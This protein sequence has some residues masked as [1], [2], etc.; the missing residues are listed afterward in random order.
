M[1]NYIFLMIILSSRLYLSGML[2]GWQ[3]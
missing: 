2:W 1:S 3:T